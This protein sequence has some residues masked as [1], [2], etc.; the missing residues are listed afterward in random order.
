MTNSPSWQPV[1]GSPT[2]AT[3]NG[4]GSRL[5]HARE[6]QA[7]GH[8]TKTLYLCVIYVPVFPLM[9][10]H[11]TQKGARYTFHAKR[12]VGAFEWLHMA[13]VWS[14]IAAVVLV[15]DVIQRHWR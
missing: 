9:V 1:I 3:I 5:Y 12:P 4:I 14:C 8:F 15:A 13:K 10:Y 2:L 6:R 11:V 7:S